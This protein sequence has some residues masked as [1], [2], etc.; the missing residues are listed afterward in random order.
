M[1]WSILTRVALFALAWLAVTEAAPNTLGYGLVAVPLVVG[2]SYVLTGPVRRSGNRRRP[3]R[4][5]LAAAALFGWVVWRS[6]VGGVDVSR[7][8]LW[9]P[10]AD[11]A[12][13]WRVHTTELESDAARVTL[14][15]V[16]NLMPGT[17]SAGL[18]GARMDVHVISPDLDVSGSIAE[19]E[20]RIRRIEQLFT[21]R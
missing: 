5:G 14:A 2:V 21:G 15:F 3:F 10:R 13:E 11:I 18:D 19:L 1:T 9:L 16:M 20:R 7:R 6:V 8:A 12:P 4:A 17:L